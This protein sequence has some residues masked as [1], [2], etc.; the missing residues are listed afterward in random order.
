ML[1]HSTDVNA[2]WW[3]LCDFW[4]L[5]GSMALLSRLWI[6]LCWQTTRLGGWYLTRSLIC[7]ICIHIVCLELVICLPADRKLSQCT[8]VA[9]ARNTQWAVNWT[10]VPCLHRGNSFNLCQFSGNVTCRSCRVAD[11]PRHEKV[12]WLL[13]NDVSRELTDFLL[14][15][16]TRY[17]VNV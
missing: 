13:S 6:R 3:G 5:E 11:Q 8:R 7:V 9:R 17:T 2:I 12:T 15:Y 14:V 1:L 4:H 10:T 16:T